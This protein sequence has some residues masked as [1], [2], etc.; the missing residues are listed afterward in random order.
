MF[1]RH[2]DFAETLVHQCADSEKY[3]TDHRREIAMVRRHDMNTFI[4][5]L[6]SCKLDGKKVY[7]TI[8]IKYCP[9]CG[10]DLEKDQET[11]KVLNLK[12]L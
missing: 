1:Y 10:V 4:D 11:G 7:K 2:N 8:H 3:T 6:A 9:Y 5:V 12:L